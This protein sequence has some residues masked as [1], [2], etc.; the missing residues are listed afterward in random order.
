MELLD[1]F[2][3]S[4]AARD[5]LSALRDDVLPAVEEAKRMTDEAYESGRIELL[6]LLDAQRVLIDTRLAE[7]EALTTWARAVADL[8]RSS[9]VDLQR[10]RP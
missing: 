10:R 7:I 3:R 9:G 8:E 4:E 2:L 5:K 1:A 6:R